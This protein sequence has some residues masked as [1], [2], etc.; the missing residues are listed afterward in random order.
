[1]KTISSTSSGICQGVMEHFKTAYV[2][3]RVHHYILHHGLPPMQMLELHSA[4]LD[5]AGLTSRS[6]VAG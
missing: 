1:M 2:I 5:K 4:R 6:R 3:K